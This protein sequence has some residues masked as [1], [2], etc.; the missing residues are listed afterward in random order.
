MTL[1]NTIEKQIEIAAPLARVW[2]AL[3]DSRQ[4]G[5][6]FRVK[7]DAPFQAGQPI[8]GRLTHPR[9]EHLQMKFSVQTITPMSYFAYTWHPYAIDPTVDYS[10]EIPTLVEFRL[11]ALGEGSTRL[12]V[13]ESGFEKLP[14]YRYAD[15]FRMNTRGWEQQLDNIAAYATSQSA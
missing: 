7:F 11:D 14:P 4:F 10:A 8:I 6:W 12:Q 1:P 5:E 3:T 15:A 13:T 9:Y 2:Q